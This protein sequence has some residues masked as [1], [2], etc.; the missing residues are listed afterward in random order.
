MIIRQTSNIFMHRLNAKDYLI[1]TPFAR[2]L[3]DRE[4]EKDNKVNALGCFNLLKNL[5]LEELQKLRSK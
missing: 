1:T 4:G 3:F 2:E 5:K